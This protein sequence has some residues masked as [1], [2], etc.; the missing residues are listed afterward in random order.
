M[1][2]SVPLGGRVL[3]SGSEGGV[4][5]R[6][7]VHSQVLSFKCDSVHHS[8]L[9]C[10]REENSLVQ[11]TQ[12]INAEHKGSSLSQLCLKKPSGPA[13]TEQVPEAAG[14]HAWSRGA[15]QSF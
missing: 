6:L 12:V 3:P 8:L 10:L 9:C 1:A 11:R 4:T 15:G 7:S 14:K 2:V 5:D 13:W